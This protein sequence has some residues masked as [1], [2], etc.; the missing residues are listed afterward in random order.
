[1]ICMNNVSNFYVLQA[2]SISLSIC[3]QPAR[4]GN[5][6]RIRADGVRPLT[7]QWY[8]KGDKLCDADD[9]DYDGYATDNLV[10]K[11]RHLLSEGVFKCQVKDKFGNSV[12]SDELGKYK[13]VSVWL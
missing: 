2:P 9:Q 4:K 12:E 10:I 13:C 11:N 5:V 7:Y 3:E 6:I 8:S 1:M